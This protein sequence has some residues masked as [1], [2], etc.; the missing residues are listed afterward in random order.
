VFY[1]KVTY[2]LPKKKKFIV[3]VKKTVSVVHCITLVS[4]FSLTSVV[5]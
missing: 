1:L 2:Y 3:R 4:S 5:Y